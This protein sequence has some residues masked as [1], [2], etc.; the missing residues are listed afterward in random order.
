MSSSVDAVTPARAGG[1]PQHPS[2]RAG[3]LVQQPHE[4]ME[5]PAENLERPREQQRQRLGLLQRDRLRNE[6]AEHDAQVRED[7]EGDRVREPARHGIAEEPGDERRADGTDE[8]PED[9][10][11]DLHG[12]DEADGLVHQPQRRRGTPRAA[13]RDLFQPRSARRDERVLSRHEH[14]IAR[15]Q[16]EHHEDAKGV[17]HAAFTAAL[18]LGGSSS[19][20]A[21]EDNDCAGFRF[22]KKRSPK[23]SAQSSRLSSLTWGAKHCRKK[24]PAS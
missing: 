24:S 12:A 7:D 5:D 21:S 22:P 15:D 20:E 9:R 8:D 19:K 23:V 2:D 18:V 13:L 17:A 14:G 3:R 1:T 11:P 16:G 10:D 4:R 6:L